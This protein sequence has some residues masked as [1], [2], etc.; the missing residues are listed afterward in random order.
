MA[1]ARADRVLREDLKAAGFTVHDTSPLGR[2][3]RLK[4]EG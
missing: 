4:G 1:A 3:Y 2:E